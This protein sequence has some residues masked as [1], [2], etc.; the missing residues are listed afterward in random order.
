MLDVHNLSITFN[1]GTLDEKKALQDINLHLKEG[2]FVTVIG[3]NG[4]G[5]S[6]LMNM[7]SGSLKPDIGTVSIND[8]DVTM[9]PEYKRSKLIGRVFQDPMAGTAPTMTIE[10]NLAMAYARNKKRSLRIG[11]NKKRKQM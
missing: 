1:E 3:S 6:T 9:L 8:K 5:K 7:I 4:A 11:V 10:E 2:D